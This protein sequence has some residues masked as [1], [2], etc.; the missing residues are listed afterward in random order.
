M[1]T[2]NKETEKQCD[3]P[4]VSS[5]SSEHIKY[6]KKSGNKM[7][8]MGKIWNKT[9]DGRPCYWSELSYHQTNDL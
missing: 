2:E 3:I 4:V 1:N 8:E 6:A 7:D 9:K 5:S